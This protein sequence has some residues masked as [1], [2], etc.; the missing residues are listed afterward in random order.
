MQNF[1]RDAYEILA[2]SYKARKDY[3]QALYYQERAGAARDS[4]VGLEKTN[5]VSSLQFDY[6]LKKKELQ[7]E[8]MRQ[9]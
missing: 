4:I 1:T 7:I 3:A 8:A 9:E 2:A 6:E 5:L